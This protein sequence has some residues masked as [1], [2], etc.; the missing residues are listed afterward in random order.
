MVRTLLDKGNRKCP[1]CGEAKERL[2]RHWSFCEFP[3]LDEDLRAFL[4]GILLGGG[5]LLGNGEDTKHLL[6]KTTS[7]QLA[8]WL[9]DEL[10]WLAHSLR[11]ETFDGE[12]KSLYHVRTHAHTLLHSLR[13]DWYSDGDKHLQTGIMLSSRTAR[14]WW[15]LAGSIEWTGDY[16]S[17]VRGTFSAAA[18]VR[19]DAITSILSRMGFESSRLDRRVSIYADDLRDWLEWI[20]EPIPGVEH[21]WALQKDVYDIYRD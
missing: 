10:G 11:R 16:D 1:G 12:R 9:F 17:Q 7:K 15:A 6:V 5:S 4:T 14:L 8:R 13:G 21:K 18:N 2:S 19:A 20:G 3:V